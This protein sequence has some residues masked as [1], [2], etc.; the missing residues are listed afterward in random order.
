[1]I[2]L[3]DGMMSHGVAY[4]YNRAVCSSKGVKGDFLRLHSDTTISFNITRVV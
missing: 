4:G 1:M 2:Y 3:K